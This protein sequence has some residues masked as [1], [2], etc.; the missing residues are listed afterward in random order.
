MVFC[1][2]LSIVLHVTCASNI[3]ADAI[4]ISAV[5]LSKDLVLALNFVK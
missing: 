2:C 1:M 4:V 5:L 3:D